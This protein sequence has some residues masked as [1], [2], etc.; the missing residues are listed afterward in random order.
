[1]GEW[2]FL[3]Y[4]RPLLTL[5][6]LAQV[7][8]LTLFARHAWEIQEVRLLAVTVLFILLAVLGAWATWKCVEWAGW[9]VLVSMSWTVAVGLWCI[10]VGQD[11]SWW[12]AILL[13]MISIPL[14]IWT[15]EP[16]GQ[17]VTWPVGLFCLF[18][19]LLT[20]YVVFWGL[21]FPTGVGF[22]L[23]G[24][25]KG[26]NDAM[27]FV[28]QI[29]PLHARFIG[30]LYLGATI[31]C[32]WH[33][34]IRRWAVAWLLQVLIFL[35]TFI[36]L[37]VTL[38]HLEIFNWTAPSV[39][40]WFMAYL[41]FPVISFWILKRIELSPNPDEAPLSSW[42]RA[43]LH[44]QG[45]G[46][47]VLGLLGFFA[48]PLLIKIWPWKLPELLSHLYSAPFVTFGLGSILAATVRGE[49]R[50]AVIPFC[51]ATMAMAVGALASSSIHQ[52]KFDLSAPS[53]WVWYA[54]LS[55]MAGV[56]LL[57]ALCVGG[58]K[59]RRS[60]GMPSAHAGKRT[61]LS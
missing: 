13:A 6:C 55:G 29:P 60:D 2:R 7:P 56:N 28:V 31:I 16:Y 52:D 45:A 43:W 47:L 4:L 36:L 14:V 51:A 39:W 32:A 58:L 11:A 30:S 35:W 25:A 24:F 34:F 12:A 33:I 17:G 38:R 54:V 37:I 8:Y 20:R 49:R 26:F 27:P 61:S 10:I 53:T 50:E 5:L 42:G 46:L 19:L 41:A 40:H 57:L 9:P 21:F 1:M 18:V 44:L 59:P 15:S 48:A 23:T 3:G 22:D